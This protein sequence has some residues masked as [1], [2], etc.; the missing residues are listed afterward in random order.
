MLNDT[1]PKSVRASVPPEKGASAI[2]SADEA[3]ADGILVVTENGWYG[4][5]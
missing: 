3:L 5:A 1:V 4:C 2:H